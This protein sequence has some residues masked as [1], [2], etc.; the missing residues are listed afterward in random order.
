[1][2]I[3]IIIRITLNIKLEIL[4]YTDD[5]QSRNHNERRNRPDGN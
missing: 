4:N 5:T 3:K 1:M 2:E